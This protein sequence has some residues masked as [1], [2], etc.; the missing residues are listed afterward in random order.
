MKLNIR[1]KVEPTVQ[2]K[3]RF[4][5]SLNKQMNDTTE[6]ADELGV[7][8]HATLI[9]AVEQFNTELNAR[10]RE[11]KA[12]GERPTTSGTTNG[13]IVEADRGPAAEAP[14]VSGSKEPKHPNT[15]KT[16]ADNVAS[17]GIA[18]GSQRDRA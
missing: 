12:K 14:T 17:N 4:S 15:H 9:A 13:L 5:V 18:D 11:M 8:Y 2:R 6:L 7:D 10:L 3:L 16:N 1:T